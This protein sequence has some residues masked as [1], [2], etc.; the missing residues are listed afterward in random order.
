MTLRKIEQDILTTNYRTLL[1]KIKEEHELED[2]VLLK[3]PLSHCDKLIY[4]LNTVSVKILESF[5]VDTKI[6][7][8]IYPEMQATRIVK[9]IWGKNIS[10]VFTLLDFK[11]F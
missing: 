4:K 11:N 10:E 8:K 9:S 7:F 2:L 5:F 1:R 6:T 3:C